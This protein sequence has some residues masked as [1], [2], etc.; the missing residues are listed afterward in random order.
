M[1]E[2]IELEKETLKVLFDLVVQSLDFEFFDQE[3]AKTI[4]KLAEAIGVCPN[5]GTPTNMLQY[6]SDCG[7]LKKEQSLS[8]HYYRHLQH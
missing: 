3:D 1:T 4:R 2:K 6:F 5:Y 8:T 7:F